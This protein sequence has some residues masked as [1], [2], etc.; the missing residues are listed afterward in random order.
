VHDHPNRQ[1]DRVGEDMALAAFDH[2]PGRIA[3]RAAG[4]GGLARVVL[5]DRLSITPAVG[6][7]ARPAASRTAISGT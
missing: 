3:T 1:A 6:L 7:A 2:L 5:T 4:P